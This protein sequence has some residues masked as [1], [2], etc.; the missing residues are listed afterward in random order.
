MT[1]VPL[2]GCHLSPSDLFI[3]YTNIIYFQ[4]TVV[5]QSLSL[6]EVIFVHTPIGLI[7]LDTTTLVGDCRSSI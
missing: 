7:I 4:F 5:L 3:H 6:F 2:P 1:K